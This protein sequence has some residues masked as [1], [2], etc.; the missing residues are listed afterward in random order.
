DP[1]LPARVTK[2]ARLEEVLDHPL[3]TLFRRVNPLTNQFDLWE[4]TTLYQE[5]HGSAYWLLRFDGLGVPG[6]IWP[7]PAQHVTPRREPGSPNVVDGYEYR[8][9]SEVRRYRPG[10]VIHFRYPDPRNPYVAGL[11]PLRACY[12]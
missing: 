11:S 8:V 3:L 10:E 2:A 5:V 1:H 12:E 9:G 7:L 4:L 6:E